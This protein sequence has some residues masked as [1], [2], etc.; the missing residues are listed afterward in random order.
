MTQGGLA[1][2]GTRRDSREDAGEQQ[3]DGEEETSCRRRSMV[4]G[5]K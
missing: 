4:S 2:T 5:S 1:R 3:D